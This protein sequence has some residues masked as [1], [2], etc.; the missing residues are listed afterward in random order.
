M[1]NHPLKHLQ[2]SKK[3]SKIQLDLKLPVLMVIWTLM[4]TRGSLV[5]RATSKMKTRIFLRATKMVSKKM[6]LRRS[7]HH[8]KKRKLAPW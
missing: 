4:R 1:L 7:R 6:M 3:L 8:L 2:S 5:R